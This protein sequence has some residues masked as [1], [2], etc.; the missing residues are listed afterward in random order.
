MGHLEEWFDETYLTDDSVGGLRHTWQG[1]G[2]LNLLSLDNDYIN[3]YS[4]AC[5]LSSK[6]VRLVN[7]PGSAALMMTNL[8][9]FS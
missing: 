4:S 8:S 7:V 5:S 6:I 3:V 2:D 9:R 1:D